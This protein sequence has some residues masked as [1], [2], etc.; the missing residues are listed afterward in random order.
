MKDNKQKLNMVLMFMLGIVLGMI[1]TQVM[2]IFGMVEF[3]KYFAD[4]VVV[5]DIN[6][7]EAAEAVFQIMEYE[8]LVS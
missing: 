2:F 8:G 3:L 7:T 5:L 1:I 6:E 4:A